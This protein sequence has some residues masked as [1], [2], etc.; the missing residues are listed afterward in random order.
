MRSCEE[1]HGASIGDRCEGFLV[2]DAPCGD[3]ASCVDGSLRV[4]RRYDCED[5]GTARDATVG[6]SDACAP[7]AP[8]GARGCHTSGDCTPTRFEAFLA[9]DVTIDASEP[10]R[11]LEH[12]GPDARPCPPRARCEPGPGDDGRGCTRAPCVLDLDCG[13]RG[14]CLGGQC[15]GELGRCVPFP[16]TEAA[17]EGAHGS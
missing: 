13:C 10:P 1:A 5:A 8:D 3:E 17:A 11:A 15:Y 6:P 2:C 7:T 9:P 14:A 4:V 12:C 16:A